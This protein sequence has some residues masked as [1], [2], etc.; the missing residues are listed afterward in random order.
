M[1]VFISELKLT[2]LLSFGP[3]GETIPLGP[4]NVLIG[5]NGSG[6]SNII[7]AISLLQAAPREI[8]KP[9]SNGGGASEWGWKGKRP[10]EVNDVEVQARFRDPLGDLGLLVREWKD[11]IL[12]HRVGFHLP[13][14]GELR[15]AQISEEISAS[16]IDGTSERQ[17]FQNSGV[18][19]W[20]GGRVAAWVPTTGAKRG[21][22]GRVELPEADLDFTKSIL[23]QRRDPAKYPEITWLSQQCAEIR[24]YADIRTG[25]ESPIRG[26]QRSDAEGSF[27]TEDGS[28]LALVLNRF[29]RDPALE[30][31]VISE[32]N[33]FAEEFEG[34]AFDTFGGRMLLLLKE[35]NWTTPATRLSD[36]TLRYLCLLAILLHPSPPP[37]ICIEEPELGLH[38]D[39][40]H[41][42]AKLLEEASQRTQ[43]IVTTHSDILIDAL[44]HTPESVLV[45]EKHEGRTKVKRLDG[46]RLKP[47]LELA[48]LGTLWR[49]GNLGG[50]RW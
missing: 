13:S 22:N 4:L 37:L 10:P 44:S 2:N 45:C 40:I 20:F 33:E 35:K 1:S 21:E 26:A 7:S 16:K 18:M 34:Y 36:G 24:I 14:S 8:T 42:L 41:R 38:P 19:R 5:P 50:N 12:I 27:L 3:E 29:Q 23:A 48:S 28:N 39:M 6:K 31:R 46:E 43:L 11:E 9:M 32:L 17:V 47:F 15:S 30:R 49:Q 25:A